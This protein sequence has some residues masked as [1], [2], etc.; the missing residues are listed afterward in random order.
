MR[1]NQRELDGLAAGPDRVDGTPWPVRRQRR[2]VVA[3][4]CLPLCKLYQPSLYHCHKY[5]LH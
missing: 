2:A 3:K 5:F 1:I 4:L